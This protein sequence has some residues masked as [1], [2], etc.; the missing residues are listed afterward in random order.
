MDVTITHHNKSYRMIINASYHHITTHLHYTTYIPF[1]YATS[2]T[3][4][5]LPRHIISAF[6]YCSLLFGIK[7]S[8][9]CFCLLHMYLCK[10]VGSWTIKSK[11]TTP[12]LCESDRPFQSGIHQFLCLNCLCDW[13]VCLCVV[14]YLSCYIGSVLRDFWACLSENILG[15]L[16]FGFTANALFLF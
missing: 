8:F 10:A 7:P 6:E 5:T 13:F 12:L 1:Y 11:F 9:F 14:A 16:D 3:I 4:R 2:Y 15:M